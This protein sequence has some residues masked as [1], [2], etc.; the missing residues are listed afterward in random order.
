[1]FAK[2]NLRVEN[3]ESQRRKTKGACINQVFLS[4]GKKCTEERK[5]GG[6]EGDKKEERERSRRMK[7]GNDFNSE[8]ESSL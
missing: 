6:G 5:K 1:M 4:D 2:L 7:E 8:N 3:I